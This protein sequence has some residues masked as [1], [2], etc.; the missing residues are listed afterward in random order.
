[1]RPFSVFDTKELPRDLTEYLKTGQ[2][3]LEELVKMFGVVESVKV[4]GISKEVAPWVNPILL[5]SN[6]RTALEFL[7]TEY[8]GENLVLVAPVFYKRFSDILP[9]VSKLMLLAASMRLSTSSN[10]QSGS[11]ST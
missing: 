10:E 7:H 3:A 9:G 6:C 4:D 8:R 2:S 5:K 11:T 1:M